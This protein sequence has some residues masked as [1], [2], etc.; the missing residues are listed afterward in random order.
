MIQVTL[1]LSGNRNKAIT[2]V[3]VGR[4]KCYYDNKS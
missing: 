4:V 3:K 1:V 2:F